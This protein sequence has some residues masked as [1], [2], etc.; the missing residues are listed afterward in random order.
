MRR[1]EHGQ[2]AAA[3]TFVTFLVV[4]FAIGCIGLI[5]ATPWV[6]FVGIGVIVIGAIVGKIMQMMGMGQ[7]DRRSHA[8]SP[9][10]PTS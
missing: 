5:V 3:W 7:Y 8:D 1:S 2:T 9:S 4:G 10:V 6:V